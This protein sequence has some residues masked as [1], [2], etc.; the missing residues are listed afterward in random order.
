M[1]FSCVLALNIFYSGRQCLAQICGNFLCSFSAAGMSTAV[2]DR[3]EAT[4]ISKDWDGNE[5][6]RS[7]LRNDGKLRVGNE[8]INVATTA[9]NEALLTPLLHRMKESP[10]QKLPDVHSLRDEI[11]KVYDMNKLE[12]QATTIIADGWF[13][14]KH[15]ALIKLKIR[16]CEPSIDTRLQELNKDTAI[17]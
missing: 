9:Q 16:R 14:R 2:R 17:M 4:G 1:F 12:V 10:A 5:A 8:V 15:L 7:C 6:L 11:T 13:I 3:V